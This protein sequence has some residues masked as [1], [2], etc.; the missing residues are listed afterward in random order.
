MHMFGYDNPLSSC[1]IFQ[2]VVVDLY[3][4]I[5]IYTYIF[6]RASNSYWAE[7]VM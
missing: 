2:V 6:I 5:Y 7:F 4:H 1:D 3:T